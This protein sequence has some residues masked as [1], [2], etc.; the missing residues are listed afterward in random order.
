[1]WWFHRYKGVTWY[2][3]YD[4]IYQTNPLEWRKSIGGWL[5][6]GI[7]GSLRIDRTWPTYTPQMMGDR[8][9]MVMEDVAET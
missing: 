9:L 1:M 4:Y 3:W 8:L 5:V 6:G 7:L 2:D